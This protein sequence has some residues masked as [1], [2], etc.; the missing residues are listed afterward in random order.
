MFDDFELRID[1]VL[2]LGKELSDEEAYFF[3]YG[4]LNFELIDI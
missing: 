1:A 2:V 4:G 3:L